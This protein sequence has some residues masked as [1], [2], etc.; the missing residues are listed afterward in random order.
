MEINFVKYQGTGNDFVIIDNRNRQIKKEDQELFR[1]LCDRKFG[2]GADGVM[3]LQDHPAF[4]FEMLYYNADGREAS[5]CGN[6]GRCLTAFASSLGIIGKETNFL[7]VDGPHYAKISANLVSLRM[8]DVKIEN[9]KEEEGNYI[10]NTGSPHYVTFR[11]GVREMDVFTEGRN[12][13]YSEPFKKAGINVNFVEEESGY[14]FV[15]TYERGVEDETLSCGT[16]V[17]AVALS[18]G[19]KTGQKGIH[20]Y[21]IHTPGGNLQVSCNRSDTV[22][23]DIYLN[24]PADFVFTGSIQF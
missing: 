10:L 21:Q 6:G 20:T 3:L 7:A 13:R 12:I 19:M 11:K 14:Y 8:S 17:T 24:G 22:F 9:I 16:G 2:V 4:D 18:A 15:R 23:T 1:K 5:M